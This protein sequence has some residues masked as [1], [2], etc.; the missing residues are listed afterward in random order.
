MSITT[1]NSSTIEATVEGALRTAGLA[2]Y[3]AQARPV[4]EALVA[5]EQALSERLVEVGVDTLDQD[6]DEVRGLLAETGMHVAHPEVEEESDES[7]T[8]RILDAISTLGSRL[9]SLERIARS[10]GLR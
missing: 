10:H 6:E 8:A 7:S 3:L 1:Q 4:I 5:R 2:S 9:D